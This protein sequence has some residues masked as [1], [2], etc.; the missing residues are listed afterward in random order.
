[1]LFA[2]FSLV[3]AVELLRKL[4]LKITPQAARGKWR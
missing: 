1:L 4:G 2:G 3:E